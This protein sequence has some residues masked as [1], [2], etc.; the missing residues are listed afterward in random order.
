MSSGYGKTCSATTEPLNMLT[1]KDFESG[2]FWDIFAALA[3]ILAST[4][5]ALEAKSLSTRLIS[6]GGV[7]AKAKLCL[8]IALC[9]PLIS[10][11]FPSLYILIFLIRDSC[12]KISLPYSQSAKISKMIKIMRI[13]YLAFK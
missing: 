7:F 1:A 10:F 13:F 11:E 8:E 6:T 3:C 12:T 4:W 2:A 5:G 9:N